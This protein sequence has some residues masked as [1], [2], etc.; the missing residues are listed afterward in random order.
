MVEIALDGVQIRVADVEA[1]TRSYTLLLGVAAATLPTGGRRFQLGCGAVEIEEGEPGAHAVR[2]VPVTSQSPSTG[3]DSRTLPETFHGLAVQIAPVPDTAPVPRAA[4]DAALAIDHVVVQTTS[5][6]RAIALWRDRI[7]LRLA[8]D[9]EFPG[10]AMRL[11]FFRSAAMTLEYAS[12]LP[13][14]A[15]DAADRFYGVSY[16]V[17]NLT[18][19]RHRLVGA[20]VEVS[21]IRPGQRPSTVVASVRS[22]TCDVPTLLIERSDA[23][24]HDS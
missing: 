2:F 24:R 16:R 4:P 18:A 20:G 7:G 6:E 1:A 15:A 19:V 13:P 11:L 12:P 21:D 22:G 8:L 9:R 17:G 23:D 5:P 10:R 3:E 14:V